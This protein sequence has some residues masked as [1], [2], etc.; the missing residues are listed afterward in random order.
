[1]P[2]VLVLFALRTV[3]LFVTSKSANYSG[4]GFALARFLGIDL[5]RRRRRKHTKSKL[6]S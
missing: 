3:G 5:C 2:V 1:M 6:P 4:L